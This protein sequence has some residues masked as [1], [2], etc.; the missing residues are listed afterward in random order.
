MAERL[1]LTHGCSLSNLP[2]FVAEGAGLFEAEGLAVEVPVFETLSSTADIMTSG[3]AEMGTEG[4]T[5][6][7]VDGHKPNPPIIVA[8]SGLMG[9]AIL[10]QPQFRSMAD[11]RG[12]RIGT[13]RSD[14]MEVHLYDKL[15]ASGMTWSDVIIDY[16]D[17]AE[18]AIR[19]FKEKR[20]DAITLAEPH[21][22]RV[23]DAGA[24]ELSDATELWGDPFPDTV[25]VVSKRLLT[26]RPHVV[27]GAIR[28]MLK[29]ERM[30]VADPVAA[31]D[32]VKKH[33]PS[34][35]LDELVRGQRRQ[36][37]C[38]DIRRFVQT[39]YDRWSS[40]KALA[41]VP[42]E[43]ELP[44]GA[45]ALDLLEAELLRQGDTGAKMASAKR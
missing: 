14:P 44:R 12:K 42:P 28:A 33:Y 6:P 15:R 45:I 2:L 26:E 1:T 20:L 32:H 24:V 38:I 9:I 30:I 5:Q 10:A 29:A 43:A 35:S 19:A 40:L 27:T 31:L 23:R 4:F 39:T 17:H 7:L 37:P 16:Q 13:F 18:N 36:P 11:L 34:Y 3:L 41:L 25:L 21:G 8:G 22:I